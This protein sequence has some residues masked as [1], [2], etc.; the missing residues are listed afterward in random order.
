[1]SL[2]RQQALAAYF[3]QNVNGGVGRQPAPTRRTS[4]PPRPAPAPQGASAAQRVAAAKAATPQKKSG[5]MPNPLDLVREGGGIVLGGALKAMDVSGNAIPALFEEATKYIPEPL[6]AVAGP[7]FRL[8]DEERE[9]R[10]D[11][12]LEK[13]TDPEFGVGSIIEDT[14]N[15]WLDRGVGF[16]GDV[17]LDPLTYVGGAGVKAAA[18]VGKAG[19]RQ[20][21]QNLARAGFDDDVVGSAG[22]FGTAFLDDATREAGGA[23][24][25]GLYA[26]FGKGAKRIP[27]TG[28]LARGI[29]RGLSKTRANTIS[30]VNNRVGW[31]M[32]STDELLEAEKVLDTGKAINGVTPTMAA[33]RVR[34]DA[35]F[36]MATKSFVEVESR[37]VDSLLKSL[38]REEAAALSDVVE[39]G[40]EPRFNKIYRD[41]FDKMQQA[42]I[43]VQEFK[44]AGGFL[45]HRWTGEARRFFESDPRGKRMR[46]I[47][48]WNPSEDPAAVQRRVIKGKTAEIDVGDGRKVTL[49]ASGDELT[50]KEINDQLQKQLGVDFK[51]LEDDVRRLTDGYIKEVG[52]AIGLRQAYKGLAN[53][54]SSVVQAVDNVTVEQ[55]DELSKVTRNAD[56]RKFLEKVVKDRAEIVGQR[57]AAAAESMNELID[58]LDGAFRSKAE[59][60]GNEVG[61]LKDDLAKITAD[62]ESGRATQQD[63]VAQFDQ[64][65]QQADAEAD[66]ILAEMDE[67]DESLS[68]ID[69]AF[70]MPPADG[71]GP[72]VR[73][74]TALDNARQNALVARARL[75]EQLDGSE[76]AVERI[77][78]LQAEAAEHFETMRYARE[79]ADD[80]ERVA[81]VVAA[82]AAR[83]GG[84]VPEFSEQVIESDAALR[85]Q[86]R[87]DAL[88]SPEV[89]DEEL[90][91]ALQVR[92]AEHAL[93]VN[94]KAAAQNAEELD[95]LGGE[96]VRLR[97]QSAVPYDPNSN[98]GRRRA[99][100]ERRVDEYRQRVAEHR[101]R[102]PIN[103]DAT[104]AL[105]AHRERVGRLGTK[106]QQL[107]RDL[108]VV[109]GRLQALAETPQGGRRSQSV[110]AE[111]DEKRLDLQI[112]L[113]EVQ[114]EIMASARQFDAE[115]PVI[116]MDGKTPKEFMDAHQ[117]EL[118]ELA[119]AKRV[120]AEV[121]AELE[122]LPNSPIDRQLQAALDEYQR[123]GQRGAQLANSR[124]VLE[125]ISRRSMPSRRGRKVTAR[126]T[127]KMMEKLERH[128]EVVRV[129]QRYV[130]G[131]QPV[132]KYA[133][134]RTFD[135]IAA[136]IEDATVRLAERD[137][138]NPIDDLRAAV[139]PARSELG[140]EVSEEEIEVVLGHLNHI[141]ESTRAVDRELKQKINERSQL[142][143]VRRADAMGAVDG[144]VDPA[145]RQGM[146]D[147]SEQYQPEWARRQTRSQSD[148]WDANDYDELQDAAEGARTSADD[149]RFDADRGYG[150][151]LDD[152]LDDTLGYDDVESASWDD[153]AMALEARRDETED[154]FWRLSDEI[155]QLRETQREL[156]K[157]ERQLLRDYGIDR[158]ELMDGFAYGNWG[159]VIM[160]AR[161]KR[162]QR[163][164]SWSTDGVPATVQELRD[165]V[166]ELFS[167]AAK[168][169]NE[170]VE[171]TAR[172]QKKSIPRAR[173]LNQVGAFLAAKK[174]HPEIV[175]NAKTWSQLKHGQLAA[176]A[177]HKAKRFTVGT[178]GHDR[179]VDAG[180]IEVAEKAAVREAIRNM[181]NTGRRAIYADARHRHIADLSA[182]MQT[183]AVLGREVADL[184]AEMRD[185]KAVEQM[186]RGFADQAEA[187]GNRAATRQVDEVIDAQDR[188]TAADSRV[189]E[190]QW[191]VTKQEQDAQK[192][193][194]DELA[195]R[196][197]MRGRREELGTQA[198]VVDA[199]EDDIGR[200]TADE[201]ARLQNE[202]ALLRLDAQRAGRE[203]ESMEARAARIKGSTPKKVKGTS[204]DA[205]LATRLDE[206]EE[207]VKLAEA[208]DL[209]ELA[210][211]RELLDQSAEH[212]AQLDEGV[213]LERFVREQAK[214]AKNGELLGD[215]VIRQL[216]DEFRN[217]EA[218]VFPEGADLATKAEM[219]RLLTNLQTEWRNEAKWWEYW[220]HLNQT[221]K[222]YATMTPGF[223]FRNWFSA[224]FMNMSEGVGPRRHAQAMSW[225]RQYVNAAKGKPGQVNEALDGWIATLRRDNPKVADAFEAVWGSGTGGSFDAAELG[226]AFA[227]GSWDALQNNMA[228]KGSRKIG[229]DFVEGPV[230]L[231]L[232]L[233]VIENGGTKLDAMNT[234]T[235][236]HFDYSQVSSFDRWAKRVIPFWTFMSRNLP[237]Q[238][239]QMA[240]KPRAYAIY[241]H[242]QNNFD[243][244]E[245]EDE[246]MPQWMEEMGGIVGAR[247]VPFLGG[248]DMVLNPD[249]PHLSLQQEAEQFF[250]NPVRGAVAQGSP[251]LKVPIELGTN[252]NFFFDGEL[253]DERAGTPGGPGA[254]E[255]ADY[256]ARSVMPTYGQGQRLLGLGRYK[257]RNPLES[258][259]NYVGLPIRELGDD[260]RDREKARREYMEARAG[261]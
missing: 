78:A 62:I 142:N 189:R 163:I 138:I 38:S 198:D 35:E 176:L 2:S 144:D 132:E 59:S 224:T 9:G 40:A 261:R 256:L 139:P 160:V 171:A 112:E 177:G 122:K 49:V 195:R 201:I 104:A 124:Q 180:I 210:A 237:L 43:P 63:V 235:R 190:E 131:R 23:A 69:G 239:E 65:L 148:A 73:D 66:R 240:R 41:L 126:E 98:V 47:F 214:K 178:Q 187:R 243:Q 71:V 255:V 129:F 114:D 3:S 14:G 68:A 101:R 151:E 125:D 109:R 203:V 95:A 219:H 87:I 246:F 213:A 220:D 51:F 92:N 84:L 111:L 45:P 130:V 193:I 216:A 140:R 8:I 46:S 11:G 174:A 70:E 89:M 182:E 75:E 90:A 26:G 97:Q 116:W 5:G 57:R 96:I 80:P 250:P 208:E 82:T 145:L 12:F 156:R 221:F 228:T 28:A 155:E 6:E 17:A 168:Q 20:L 77:V 185:N 257:N 117:G 249:L 103:R 206:L 39:H 58:V 91:W 161:G 147:L 253:F 234:V 34:F 107:E 209:P 16:I 192:A 158:K 200:R 29:E 64:M 169:I 172:Q 76:E 217:I 165:E 85:L 222:G 52:R 94:K 7:A 135:E 102:A 100:L 60:L 133:T 186:F 196:E 223:H 252:H 88:D 113:M 202:R 152:E 175:G 166:I 123:L 79:V 153:Q 25:S 241:Q 119:A 108:V 44:G 127:Q 13:L 42:G 19:R 67:I 204:K 134:A 137:S 121:E 120:V 143:R 33:E 128:G 149:T 24:Q 30:K 22:K 150:N 55:L 115:S 191:R 53:S 238:V 74:T 199:V 54:K 167:P 4:T 159:D 184:Q 254:G 232:A 32:R 226:R 251:Y 188:V 244:S 93:E 110:A 258:G 225:W 245:G 205:T 157:M 18:G 1:M 247:N 81:E 83:D 260:Q 15:K 248:N 173:R 50:A 231:A 233:D 212:V 207:A 164:N 141:F 86:R 259:S 36:R 183:R 181:P 197:Q 215:R 10:D 230:R 31:N 105:K 118:D 236:I 27:G 242:A 211:A 21:A 229:V 179:L 56:M 227:K 61:A 37:K 218:K 154:Y 194:D 136:E 99:A 106:R 146:V 170:G 162:G 72:A 48:E